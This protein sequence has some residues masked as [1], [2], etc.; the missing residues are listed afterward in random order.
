MNYT[1]IEW[2]G[3]RGITFEFLGMPVTVIKPNVE[4]NGKW[5]LKTEYF[6]AF[7]NTEIELLCRGWH[8][9]YQK[10]ENRWAGESD[11]A[12]KE[13]LVRFIP[14]ELSLLTQFTAVGMSCGGMYAV[15]LAARCPELVDVLYLDAPVLNLLSCPCDMGVGQSGLYS[16]FFRF[17]GMTKSEMLSYRNHPIDKIPT[18]ISHNIPIVLVAGDSDRIV[19]YSENGEILANA[20]EC[21]GKPIRKFIKPGCDHHPHGIED[22]ALLADVIEEFSEYTPI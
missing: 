8:L 15:M 1:D 4:P 12:R 16:E 21:A 14:T 17:T 10:N 2:N 5:M 18:L 6:G 13:A 20:Y 9:V 3:F 7:P 22:A 19:P 11:L